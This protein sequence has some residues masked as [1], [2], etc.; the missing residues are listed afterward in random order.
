MARAHY[1]HAASL[2]SVYTVKLHQPLDR[3]QLDLQ[4]HSL[5]IHVE[6]QQCSHA[7]NGL[8]A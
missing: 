3:F 2:A 1:E 7:L 4:L 6:L 5:F 8:K